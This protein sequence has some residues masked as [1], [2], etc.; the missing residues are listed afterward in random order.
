M[1]IFILMLLLINFVLQVRLLFIER[2]TTKFYL[3]KKL[4]LGQNYYLAMECIDNQIVS[5]LIDVLN[6]NKYIVDNIVEKG[7]H[8]YFHCENSELVFNTLTKKMRINEN[9]NTP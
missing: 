6:N 7:F 9:A 8:M 3:C 1:R 4:L 2:N 5:I